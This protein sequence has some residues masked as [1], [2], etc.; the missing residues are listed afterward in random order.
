VT[1]VAGIRRDE[2]RPATGPQRRCIATGTIGERSRLLRF[3][4]SPDGEL[5]PDVAS[6]LPGRGL[7]L[8]PRRDIVER[9]VAT[10][11]FARAARRP[12][13]VPSGLADRVEVLLAQ[14]CCDAIGLARRAGLAV[15]GFEKVSEAIRAA[16]AALVVSALDGAAGGRA[17]IRALGRD[18]P[19]ARVLTAA[20]MG[21]VFGRDRVVHVALGGGRLGTRLLADAEKLAGF[22]S[23]AALDRGEFAAGGPVRHEGSIGVK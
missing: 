4:V 17:K 22:R 21:A 16:K 9:A 7:W 20:E 12:V 10:R 8:T 19:L 6:N 14:R 1:E 5:V 2:V 13:S 11:R 15:A 18:L 23:G 3:V